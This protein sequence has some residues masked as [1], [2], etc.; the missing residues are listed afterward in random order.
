MVKPAGARDAAQSGSHVLWLVLLLAAIP[1]YFIA[2]GANSIW[3]ANEAFYVDTPRHM[4]ET[5]DFV[6]PVWNGE[7]RVNKPVLSY[8][9][10]AGLYQLFGVS[11]TVERVGIA[12]GAMLLV[13]ATF[14]IGRALR[15]PPT[16]IIAAFIVLSA[17]RVVMFSR[18]IFIDVWVTC[19]MAI[20]LACFVL[21]IANWERRRRYLLLM[22]VAIGLGVLTKGPVALVLPAAV[23]AVWLTLEGRWRDLPRLSLLPGALIV[24]SIVAPWY[25]ALYRAHGWDPVISFFVGENVGRFTSSMVPGERDFLFYVPVLFGDLFPWAP[26]LVVP[27]VSAWRPRA[28]GEDVVHA[29]IR[30]LLWC[31]IVVI[32]VA[33]SFSETKQDLYIFPTVAAVAVLVADTLVSSSFGALRAAVRWVFGAATLA[34]VIGGGVAVWLFSS[35]YYRLVS[36]RAAAAVLIAGGLA[37]LALLVVR[38]T[39]RSMLVLGAAFVVFNYL[40]VTTIL[41][42]M[43]RLK[44]A[45]P[46]ATL[47]NERVP[48]TAELGDY[49][50]A[51]PPSLVFYVK[52]PVHRMGSAEHAASFFMSS[53]GS[54]AIVEEANY[55]DLRAIVPNLCE[56]ARYPVFEAKA[57][58]LLSGQPPPDVILVTNRCTGQ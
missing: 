29:A 41:P 57:K 34:T 36:I 9:I 6:T 50:G 33:F 26:L 38:R 53:N 3:E 15:S 52:R 25:V 40:F 4:V 7:L 30:R 31:W 12:L 5:G 18:R 45:V 47:I 55:A 27:I 24:L 22:Y 28:A 8:W 16:G 42:E 13:A 20:A 51:L 39:E 19:F 21:A 54:W 1:V 14:V 2:L 46:L 56:I 37:A 44:P 11:V 43:E 35:G 49:K 23:L 32:A 10:V 17:P 48:R 58:D